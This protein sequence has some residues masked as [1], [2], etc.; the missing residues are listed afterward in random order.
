M[1][2]ALRTCVLLSNQTLLYLPR[3]SVVVTVTMSSICTRM[4]ACSLRQNCSFYIGW[5][6]CQTAQPFCLCLKGEQNVQHICYVMQPGRNLWEFWSKPLPITIVSEKTVPPSS[7]YKIFWIL[8]PPSA[9]ITLD[10]NNNAYTHI[11]NNR[12][13]KLWKIDQ[14]CLETF[15][16]WCCTGSTRSVQQNAR[17]IK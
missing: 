6:T 7:V 2:H 3:Y 10:I 5:R 16:M 17:K 13:L 15:Q 12:S 4:V 1:L 9:M 14:K 8:L 11:N